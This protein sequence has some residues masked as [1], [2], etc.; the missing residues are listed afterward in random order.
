MTGNKS[1]KKGIENS[2]NLGAFVRK[3]RRIDC[4]QYIVRN[5]HSA[6]FAKKILD[7]RDNPDPYTIRIVQNKEGERYKGELVYSVKLTNIIGFCNALKLT[8]E[9]IYF[10]D[11]FGMKPVV[12]WDAASSKYGTLTNDSN[13][14]SDFFVPFSEIN[15]KEISLCK[16]IVIAEKKHTKLA[17]SYNENSWG[18]TSSA[19]YINEMAHIVKKYF[20]LKPEFKQEMEASIS[21]VIRGKTLGIHVRGTDFLAG[22]DNHPVALTVEDYFEYIDEISKDVS[23]DYIFL[24]TDDIRILEKMIE[25]YGDKIRYYEDVLRSGEAVSPSMLNTDRKNNGYLLGK[26]IMR[27]MLTLA[28]CDSL[29]AGVSQV[30]ICARIWKRS[31]GIDYKIEKII[32]KGINHSRI[33]AKKYYHLK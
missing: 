16:N 7:I 1:K 23:F 33:T 6:E 25:N 8:V 31:T 28:A 17:K 21:K 32:D 2:M 20:F 9:Y 18:Y 13:I 24:A 29:I 12:F 3:H 4:I 5:L 11:L 22:T 30:S 14:L 27:D 10:A 15:D 26:E 19:E